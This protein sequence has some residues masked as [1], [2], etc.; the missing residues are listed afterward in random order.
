M[1]TIKKICLTIVLVCITLCA[2]LAMSFVWIDV[3]NEFMWRCF[4]TLTIIGGAAMLTGFAVS[5]LSS[6]WIKKKEGV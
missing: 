1:D 3:E 2:L 4:L 5:L 6:A